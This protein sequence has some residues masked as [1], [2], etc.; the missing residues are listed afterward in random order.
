MYE[1]FSGKLVQKRPDLA[2]ID[3]QGIGYKLR[4]TSHTYESLPKI[5]SP[6]KLFTHLNVREDALELFGFA[7]EEE[8]AFFHEL[9]LVSKIGPKAAANILSG[10]TP[11]DIQ[12]MVLA[13]DVKSLSTLPGV[14]A[15][16]ARRLV[17]EL[18]SRLEKV[19]FSLS[20]NQ[21][22]LKISGLSASEAEAVMALEALGYSRTE[23]QSTIARL[24]LPA[25]EN[26]TTQEIIKKALQR[27]K[28]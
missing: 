9:L 15:T 19:D 1:Y 24:G 3:V 27:G 25:D 26:T 6:V 23:A 22:K 18:K 5:D 10:G 14:G 21:P 12:R 8:R 4:I 20:T 7:T 16:T 17:A 2:V 13:E 28:T 11:G